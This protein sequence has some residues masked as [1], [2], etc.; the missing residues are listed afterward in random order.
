MTTEFKNKVIEILIYDFSARINDLPLSQL[1]AMYA[2]YLKLKEEA[3]N[4]V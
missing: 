1:Y 4:E 2:T 3:T